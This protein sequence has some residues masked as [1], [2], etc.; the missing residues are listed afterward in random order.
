M[1]CQRNDADFAMVKRGA[2][3]MHSIAFE[4]DALELLMRSHFV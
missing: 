4:I 1:D 2:H 3:F